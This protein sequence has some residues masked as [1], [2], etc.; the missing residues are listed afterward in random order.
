MPYFA[1]RGLPHGSKSL[2]TERP[3]ECDSACQGPGGFGDNI[4]PING[5]SKIIRRKSTFDVSGEGEADLEHLC[6]FIGF[7]SRLGTGK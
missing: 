5:Y 6:V 7:L 3:T 2:T 1:V 4:F